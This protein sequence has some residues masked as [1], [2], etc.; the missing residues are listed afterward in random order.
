MNADLEI[1][2]VLISSPRAQ[3]LLRA[4]QVAGASIDSFQLNPERLAGLVSL[5]EQRF[6][7]SAATSEEFSFRAFHP[8]HAV[9]ERFRET[10]Q[11]SVQLQGGN[12]AGSASIL[13]LGMVDLFFRAFAHELSSCNEAV[14]PTGDA[15]ARLTAILNQTPAAELL[16]LSFQDLAQEM[17]CTPRHLSRIFHAVVGMSFR[18]KQVQVRLVRAQELLATTESKVLEVAL[19]SGYQSLSLF[20]LMFK[21][22]IGMTPGQWREHSR[23][24]ES[25]RRKTTRATVMS[26]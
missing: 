13:R 25:T 20:N 22:R 15:K 26:V 14:S 21:K 23:I 19:E 12:R 24:A 10:C 8:P 9:A 2:S 11:Y 17:C 16:E 18:E 1:G 3:G 4:S 6:F 5:G 7:Q